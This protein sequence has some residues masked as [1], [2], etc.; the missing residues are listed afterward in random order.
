[1]QYLPNQIIS[2]N[3]VVIITGGWECNEVVLDYHQCV[4]DSNIRTGTRLK[5]TQLNNL[6]YNVGGTKQLCIIV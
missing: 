1:M 6:T 2:H 5:C 3:L 4:S